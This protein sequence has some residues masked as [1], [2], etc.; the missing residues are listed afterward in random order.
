MNIHKHVFTVKER[1]L[2]KKPL[3]YLYWHPLI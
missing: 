3:I 1:P 2:Q